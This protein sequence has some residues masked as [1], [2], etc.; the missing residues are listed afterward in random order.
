MQAKWSTETKSK[1]CCTLCLLALLLLPCLHLLGEPVSLRRKLAALVTGVAIVV[2]VGRGC[3]C[4]G[5]WTLL[6]PHLGHDAP[7][8]SLVRLGA[9]GLVVAGLWL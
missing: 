2:G 1:V 8:V 6:L 4:C 5:A 9:G 3:G 7:A